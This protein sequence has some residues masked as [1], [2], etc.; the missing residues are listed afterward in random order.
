MPPDQVSPEWRRSWRVLAAVIS[1]TEA[2]GRSAAAVEPAPFTVQRPSRCRGDLAISSSVTAVLTM[3]RR[4]LQASSAVEPSGTS[5][6]ARGTRNAR[7]GREAP[8]LDTAELRKN[9]PPQEP[10]VLAAGGPCQVG[11]GLHPPV[12]VLLE[13]LPAGTRVD[14]GATSDLGLLDAQ[15]RRR[16]CL[17]TKRVVGLVPRPSIGVARLV[18]AKSELADVA[19]VAPSLT[20]S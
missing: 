16:V 6:E 20:P 5:R 17:G 10:V 1:A 15:P 8:E 4:T 14:P 19:E 2:T 11:A 7:C 9:V 12:G 18:A 3:A 13:S